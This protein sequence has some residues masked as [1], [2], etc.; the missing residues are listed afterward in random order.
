MGDKFRSV[1][2]L[3]SR[4]GESDVEDFIYYDG[5]CNVWKEL[6]R[7]SEIIDYGKFDNP[8][9]WIDNVKGIE[10]IDS[11]VKDDQSKDSETNFKFVL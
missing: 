4:Y 3:K 11:E 8:R 7:A 5:K 2:V 10:F 9:W 1:I 6:P